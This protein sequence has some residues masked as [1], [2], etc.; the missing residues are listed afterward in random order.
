VKVPEVVRQDVPELGLK[1]A[2]QNAFGDST[3]NVT[4]PTPSTPST[5]TDEPKKKSGCGCDSADASGGLVFLGLLGLVRRR[6]KR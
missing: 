1:M 6:R 5:G 2:A 3:P 4:A